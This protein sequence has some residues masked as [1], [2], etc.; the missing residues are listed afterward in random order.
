[1]NRGP[2]VSRASPYMTRLCFA[3]IAALGG[4]C[5]RL[6]VE[7]EYREP[8]PTKYV[9]HSL[10]GLVL[11]RLAVANPTQYLTTSIENADSATGRTRRWCISWI[12]LH[13]WR[14]NLTIWL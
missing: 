6:N 4:L 13:D 9:S 5:R 3:L 11:R 12:R 2:N 1:M 10:H 8:L 7:C 14:T